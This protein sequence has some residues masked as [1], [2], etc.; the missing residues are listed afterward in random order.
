MRRP[1]LILS[2]VVLLTSCGRG[3]TDPEPF[4]PIGSL[5][6][7]YRGGITGTF[8]SAGTLEIAADNSF[9]PVTG[10][11]AYRQQDRL[12]L[13]ASYADAPP[14]ADIFSLLL[15]DVRR[16]GSFQI[17]P[18]PCAGGSLAECRV[19][20]FL[21]EVAASE[22]TGT[23]DLETV[24]NRSYLMITGDVTI[25]SISET[26]VKGS[27]RGIALRG[28]EPSL[29]NTITISNGAFDLPLRPR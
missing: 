4:D 28:N 15:G 14:R 17:D 11:S 22:W 23:P 12:A 16:S 25:T 9:S 26:R 18:A 10:A 3:S 1:A 5:S 8:S 29:Q 6:F 21:P 19:G 13:V 7:T 2:A 24:R 27:F 20:F